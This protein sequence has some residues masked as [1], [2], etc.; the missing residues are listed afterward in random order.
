[1]V[2]VGE[3]DSVRVWYVYPENVRAAPVVLVVHEIFGLTPWIRAVADQVAAEGYL[4]VAPDLLTGHG[5]AG[6]PE[7]PD[8]E[9]ARAAIR[10]LPR[11][12]VQRRLDAV[13]RWAMRLPGSRGSYGI[14][15]FCW[16]GAV[17]FEHAA[18]SGNRPNLQASIVFY[19][20]SPDEDLLA[21]VA[22]P[23]LGLY[24]GDDARVNAT[25]PPAEEALR[26][27]GRIFEHEIYPGAGHG[28]LRQ[29]DGRDGANLAATRAAWPRAIGFL[30]RIW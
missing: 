11:E 26:A 1:M 15:G 2:P 18:L 24:G 22:T 25:I 17:A 7:G 27:R 21:R 6:G 20:T 8:P 14:M 19:G 29:Q 3:D 9:A 28:F 13:A 16:G 30:E 5:V 4:G 23:V 12:Q 10:A